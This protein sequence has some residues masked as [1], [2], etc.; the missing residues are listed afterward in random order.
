MRMDLDTL[1]SMAEYAFRDVRLDQLAKSIHSC[2]GS[3]LGFR[4]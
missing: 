2:R 3:R 4:K 1:S